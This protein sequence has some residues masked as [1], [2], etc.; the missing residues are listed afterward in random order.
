[1]RL[2]YEAYEGFQPNPRRKQEK[3]HSSYKLQIGQVFD[4]VSDDTELMAVAV[5]TRIP[6][7]GIGSRYE[8]G[9]ET[10]FIY[11]GQDKGIQMLLR[12]DADLKEVVDDAVRSGVITR[13]ADGTWVVPAQPRPYD[14]DWD[15]KKWDWEK[16]EEWEDK[17]EQ[18]VNRWGIMRHE[19]RKELKARAEASKGVSMDQV[20]MEW[21]SGGADEDTSDYVQNSD[22][23]MLR[24]TTNV[25]RDDPALGIGRR[26]K[27]LFAFDTSDC[28]RSPLHF[29]IMYWI[30][31]QYKTIEDVLE[32]LEDHG[33]VDYDRETGVVKAV[34]YEHMDGQEPVDDPDGIMAELQQSQE[35]GWIEFERLVKSGTESLLNA[36]VIGRTDVYVFERQTPT[37]EVMEY[38]PDEAGDNFYENMLSEGD[39]D[40]DRYHDGYNDE[41]YGDDGTSDADW[42]KK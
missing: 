10:L 21:L 41:D 40:T 7:L 9:K 17:R 2:I 13:E 37:N 1:M 34:A 20:L 42:W 33:L 15:R 28:G 6:T 38:C 8:D 16:W 27:E 30:K 24:L 23:Q 29:D 19:T 22:Y 4:D 35:E 18:W 3:G 31:P 36:P 5:N 26:G 14:A 25:C 12:D 11:G 39:A 32:L